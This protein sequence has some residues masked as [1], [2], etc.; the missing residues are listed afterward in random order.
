MMERF[1]KGQ[2]EILGNIAQG[3]PLAGSLNEI[4]LLVERMPHTVEEFSWLVSGL[5]THRRAD[6]L[7]A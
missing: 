5:L 6:T 1:Y 7:G 3:A 2:C 4:V